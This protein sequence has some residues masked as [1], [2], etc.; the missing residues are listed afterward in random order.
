MIF[1]VLFCFVF[2][3]LLFFDVLFVFFCFFY[4]AFFHFFALSFLFRSFY[5]GSS[6]DMFLLIGW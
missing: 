4:V 2:D 5:L 6:V 1:F 3:V